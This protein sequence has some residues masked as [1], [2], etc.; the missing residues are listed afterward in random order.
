MIEALIALP[1]FV[2]VLAAT[3]WFH[4]L[5]A[6]KQRLESEAR[7]QAWRF[8]FDGCDSASAGAGARLTNGRTLPGS[9]ELV[10]SSNRAASASSTKLSSLSDIPV[11]GSALS[12]I[13]G[14][15]ATVERYATLPATALWGD[16]KTRDVSAS[17]TRACN[18]H[19][20]DPLSSATTLFKSLLPKLF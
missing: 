13:T 2:L 11:A 8:A 3:L 1:V 10:D 12:A 17:A 16:G 15:D 7:E 9:Q 18:E 6:T 19:K 14:R 4:S 5:L 20:R